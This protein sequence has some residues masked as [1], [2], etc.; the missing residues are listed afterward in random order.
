MTEK[1]TKKKTKKP[2]Q[3]PLMR[4]YDNLKK[5]YPNTLLLCRVGDFYEAF[6]SDA[7]KLSKLAGIVLTKRANGS[8]SAVELAGFPH[9][10]L[11][12]Y[13]PK[14]IKAGQRVAI[15][16]QLENS[17]NVK[18]LVKRGVTE[19]VTPGLSYHDHVLDTK[20]NNYLAAIHFGSPV[21]GISFLDISTGEFLTTQ[22]NKA[23]IEKL[24]ASFTPT[25][26]IFNRAEKKTFKTLFQDRYHTH[27]LEAWIYHL[28][29]GHERLNEHFGTTTLKGFGIENLPMGIIASGAILR[30]LE[31][32]EHYHLTHINAIARLEEEKYLWL[33]KF[34]ICNLELI[35]PQQEGGVSLIQILD[36][37][38]T[39]MGARMLKRW[40]LLPLKEIAPIQKRLDAVA[41]FVSDA[42]L[43]QNILH[44]LK[45]IGDLERL[46]S[47]VAAK[48]LNPRELLALKKALYHTLPIQVLLK[49]SGHEP[50][51]QLGRQLHPCDFLLEKLNKTLAENPP[52]ATNQ[53][54]LIKKGIHAELD[55]LCQMAFEG[56]DYL[57][58]MLLKARKQTGISS[59]KIS[60][61]K[62]FG[63]Y[64]E[65]THTHKDKVPAT[66]IR[67][68]TLVNAERY[69]TEEL[70]TYEEKIL[71][72]EEKIYAIE[73]Q[74]YNQLVE[75]TVVFVPQIQ[76]NAKI[77]ATL[78]CYLSFA[79]Q[80]K[81]YDYK[82]PTINTSH[83]I[84]IKSG[85]H[86]VIEQHL[87]LSK[88]YVPND[89]YLDDQAQQILL[90]TGP[91]MAGKSA[92]LRQVA[93]NVLMAQ[94]GSFVPAERATIG[95]VDKIFTRVGASDNL[96]MSESTFMVEMNEMA[97]IVNN[98]SKRSLVIVD[99]LGRGTG[100]ADGF[101]L[102]QATIEY[103]HNHAKCRAKT[104]F[105][106][107]YHD[108]N[109]LA[110][111]LERVKNFHVAVKE[112]KDKVFFLH[113]LKTGG[114]P[115]S[116]GIQV[117]KMAGIPLQIIQRAQQILTHLTASE[118]KNKTHKTIASI[119]TMHHQ[120]TL[121]EKKTP[122]NP[123]IKAL[124]KIEIN[125]LTPV[126]ALLKL[127]EL[128]NL[129]KH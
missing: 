97:S 9:H 21:L 35:H 67:K 77:L 64:L 28:E 126:E 93:L 49:E 117:A 63:Y 76:Q 13:I 124:D 43:V 12:T 10:A 41:L 110:Q 100:T 91:N 3:T 7:I 120:L 80:A 29:Y 123:L 85:R 8:A 17:K 75:S 32:T 109:E 18:G 39:P 73:Q 129:L 34:T 71:Y 106:T 51:I 42:L 36:K 92:L 23:Y 74:L 90:I 86:P 14:L 108:L 46:I 83:V 101:S 128:K 26:I 61:N 119:P 70:K 16:D 20:H 38:V 116:F 57:Q 50:L 84:D 98:L 122:P 33:D 125:T 40:V 37:T 6:G 22:G 19:L 60:Y 88:K 58:Q 54:N 15:C 48:R 2:G 103:L 53:G 1:A 65:V 56:K 25:E 102:A 45:Q 62:V 4:Q 72:A 27:T 59:L 94:I 107:H 30:Y 95:L 113:K 118:K 47:K 127:E 55:E 66:W 82:K 121:F 78:D 104:L 105:A 11:D 111:Q 114:S 5:K 99:E 112:V 52:I 81:K 68:Q 89:V 79:K 115:H 69:V 31:E 44:D 24:I 96:A 87:P